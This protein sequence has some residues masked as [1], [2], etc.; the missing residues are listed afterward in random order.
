MG[1]KPAIRI[2]GSFKIGGGFGIHTTYKTEMTYQNRTWSV[3][4]RFAAFQTL[5]GSLRDRIGGGEETML[6]LPVQFPSRRL[7][8]TLGSTLS[9]IVNMR[10]EGLQ[11]WLDCVLEKYG[12]DFASI[13]LLFGDAD[14]RGDS[15]VHIQLGEGKIVKE[16]FAKV[17]IAA[18]VFS[19]WSTVYLA[20]LKNGTLLV[21]D[22]IYDKVE[23]AVVNVNLAD[24]D[25]MVIPKANI[26]GVDVVSKSSGK[27]LKISFSS[28]EE[29]AFWIRAVSDFSTD[30]EYTPAAAAAALSNKTDKRSSSRAASTSQKKT[31]HI[32]AAGTGNTEDELSALY[33]I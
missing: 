26:C 12:E 19:V 13:F 27:K 15:G 22:S 7:V 5:Y 1:D 21:L 33:G 8:G 18:S 28:R 24:T 23:D 2:T 9:L 29:S 20:I 31:E 11:A 10:I 16:S 3:Y 6:E 17:K 14:N 25:T 30:M 32:K 4:R